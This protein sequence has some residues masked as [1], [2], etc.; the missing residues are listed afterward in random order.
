MNRKYFSIIYTI[1]SPFVYICECLFSFSSHMFEEYGVEVLVHGAQPTIQP[2]WSIIWPP[3]M[4]MKIETCK[5]SFFPLAIRLSV[6]LPPPFGQNMHNSVNGLH[7]NTVVD[8]WVDSYSIEQQKTHH[9]DLN[10][11][12][13]RMP[14]SRE[15]RLSET[16]SKKVKQRGRSIIFLPRKKL[17]KNIRHSQSDRSFYSKVSL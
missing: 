7:E 17:L 12:A 9:P 2:C 14:H 11:I 5:H 10:W 8:C 16:K 4:K 3:A 13:V 15:L 6:H 1:L